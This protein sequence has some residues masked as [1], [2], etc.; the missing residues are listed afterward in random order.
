MDFRLLG[1]L[2]VTHDAEPVRL[3]GRRPQ[4]ILAMLLL[5]HGRVVPVDR[6]I[7]ALWGEAPPATARDQVQIGVSRLRRSLPAGGTAIRTLS[8]G[9]LL[10]LGVGDTLDLDGYTETACAGRKLLAAGAVEEA[11]GRMRAALALWHGPALANVDSGLVSRIA[12]ELDEQRVSLLEECLC[13]EVR[14][15]AGDDLVTE[16]AMLTREFPLRERLRCAQMQALHWVGRRAEALHVY[17]ETR[18]LLITELGIEPSPELTELHQRLL[19]EP[20]EPPTQT[21][22]PAPAPP[23]LPMAQ[24]L[25]VAQPLAPAPAP[26]RGLPVPRLLPPAIADF[27]G[28]DETLDWIN[29]ALGPSRNVAA[30]VVPTLAVYGRGGCGK[31]TLAVHAAHQL[32]PYYPDGQLFARLSHDGIA[33]DPAIV[34]GRFL[35]VLG[36][37]GAALPLD[38]DSRSDLLRHLLG[39]R[40]MLVVLDDVDAEAQVLPLLPGHGGCGVLMTGRTRPTWIPA[41]WRREMTGFDPRQSSMMLAQYVGSARTEA[42]SGALR[43]LHRLT[44]GLPL[45]LHAVG[46]RLAARP[47][48]SLAAMAQRLRENVRLLDELEYSEVSVRASFAASYQHLS[49]DAR[50]LLRRLALI[51]A[52]GFPSQVGVPLLQT[53]PRQAEDLMGELAEHHFVRIEVDSGGGE[54]CRF[55]GASRDFALERL[56]EEDEPHERSCALERVARAR[57][58]L[59]RVA[60]RIPAGG[61]GLAGNAAAVG[62]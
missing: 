25:A 52:D 32:A 9:Y 24:P 2:S 59:S 54:T 13:A 12:A 61:F 41:A 18:R 62:G 7:L 57:F 6:L 26:D 4:T 47:H 27:I 20:V 17:R 33:L 45:A 36:V 28:R 5:D 21:P 22:A 39:S 46:S 11:I 14:V 15:R 49:E 44:D 40:R 10:E 60:V 16:L 3:S 34:L 38:T 42:E 8:P 19:H 43:E 51:T 56:L 23:P 29:E 48:I 30:P 50:R 55:R 31:T 37:V 53:G 58:D 35:R 1:P